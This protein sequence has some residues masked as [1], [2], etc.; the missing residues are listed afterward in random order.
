MEGPHGNSFL[1]L[2]LILMSSGPNLAN[3]FVLFVAGGPLSMAGP[4][5]ACVRLGDWR[6]PG[7]SY[8]MG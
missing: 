7:G 3:L 4:Y 6:H 5:I 1:V 8:F 2:E